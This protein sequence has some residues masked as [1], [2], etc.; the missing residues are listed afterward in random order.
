MADSFRPVFEGLKQVADGL[1]LANEGI[2]K[3]ADAVLE[4]RDEHE[5]LK[6]TVMRLEG[7]VVTQGEDLQSLRA[8]VKALRKHL[9]GDAV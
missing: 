8:D 1:I 2:K 4:A 7:L 5:D 9:G 3:L 6:E